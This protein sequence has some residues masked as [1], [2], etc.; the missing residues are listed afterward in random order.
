MKKRAIV[1]AVATL[2]CASVLGS[3]TGISN[4][5]AFKDYWNED[6]ISMQSIDETLVYDITFKK[7]EAS[8]QSSY[9]ID[10]KAGTYTTHLVSTTHT[11][12]K[13]AYIYT[14][15][16]QIDVTYTFQGESVTKHDFITTE[17]L[18]Y[19][20]DYALRPI[21][22]KKTFLNHS[23][24]GGTATSLAECY[25]IAAYTVETKYTADGKSGATTV[26]LNPVKEG[27]QPIVDT[28]NTF[29]IDTEDYNYLDNEQLLLALRAL[30]ATTSSANV[31]VYS[32]FVEAV[33][34]I[35]IATA[36][37]TNANTTSETDASEPFFYTVNGIVPEKG[38]KVAYRTLTLSIDD[39][40]PGATQTAWIA[41]MTDPAKN[42]N[43]NVILHLE[44]PLAYALG[45][46]VYDLRSADYKTATP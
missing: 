39:A 2:L 34:T 13:A 15:D 12:G 23:P 3:C 41:K 4:K 7:S 25:T 26:T 40:N 29:E 28:P 17:S 44:T 35:N 42:T 27:D 36:T 22:S 20:E 19:S 9:S 16:L 21:S 32:P 37:T 1:S 10:Y 18:F 8:F 38:R 11:D 31:L 30:P 6:S 5:I 24:T 33:Q 45:T 14:T 46:L 43:R